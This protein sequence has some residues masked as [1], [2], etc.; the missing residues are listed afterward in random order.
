MS[1]ARRSSGITLDSL[2]IRTQGKLDLRGFLGLSDDVPPGYEAID[3]EVRIKGDG[4]PERFRGNPP[5]GDGDLAQLLQHEPADP[6]ERHAQRRLTRWSRARIPSPPRRPGPTSQGLSNETPGDESRSTAAVRRRAPNSAPPDPRLK[7]LDALHP[8]Q[9]AEEVAE[10]LLKAAAEA[11][12]P[13]P[14][15]GSGSA[16][17]GPSTARR[18][19]KAPESVSS[20]A[21]LIRASACFGCGKPPPVRLARLE[22]R[23]L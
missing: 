4:T 17:V 3:Y 22:T 13:Q 10:A 19:G 12:S 16:P 15:P 20:G 21:F 9:S 23:A 7:G 6:D 18:K 5:D 8:G 2:E 11:G 1:P 14:G